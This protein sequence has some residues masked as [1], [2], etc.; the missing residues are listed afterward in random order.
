MTMETCLRR[1]PTLALFVTVL[2]IA[3]MPVG[4]AY[5]DCGSPANL[6]EAENCKPGNP[7]SE[8]DV[9][10]AGDENLQG[11]ATDISVDR[12]GTISFKVDTTA[13]AYRIDIYRLGYYQG[14]GA[15]LVA[16]IPNASTAK[17]SQPACVDQMSTTGLVDCGN[18]SVSASWAVP[19]DAVSG[20]YI[21]RLQGEAGVTGASHMVFVVRHD[22]S[23][24]DLLFQTSDTTW[25]AYNSYGGA[26]LY[27]GT[28][29]G[30]GLSGAGRAYKV[31]YNRP[32]NTRE[33]TPEDWI[34]D[35]E[36][37]MVRW[38]E[39]NGYDV[40]YTTGVDTAR[41]GSEILT[42]KAF[43]SVG[44]DEYWSGQQR[45]N[46]E[47]AR[48]HNP[49]VHLAFFSGNEIF[50][51]T[52]WE[53]SIAGTSTPYRTLV[54]YKETH[55]SPPEK[56][57]PSAEWTGTWRDPRFSP[58]SDGGR[59]E[60]ALSGTIFTVN[61]IQNDA[62][63][64]PEADGKMRFWRDTPNVANL[65]TGQVWSAPAGTL[66]YE[67]DEDL[68]NGARPPGLVR[69]STATVNVPGLLQDYGSTYAQGTATHHLA[70]HRR[71][72]GALVFGAGT[73]QWSWGLDSNHDRGSEPESQDMQQATVNLLADMGAQP[74][75]LQG[76]LSPASASADVV[77]PASDITSP[78]NDATA[79]LGVPVSILGTAS[80]G[81]PGLVGGVEVSVDGGA[82]WHSAAG[83][84]TWSYAWTPTT[85]GTY[86][87]LCRAVDDSGN[88]ESASAARRITVTSVP[89]SGST[90]V[91]TGTGVPYALSESAPTSIWAGT[92]T[93]ATVNDFDGQELELGVK[94]RSSSAGAITGIRFYKASRDGST[95]V[96]SLWSQSGT[97]LAAALSSTETASGWQEVALL[98]PVPIT[99]N[100]TYVASYHAKP[101]YYASSPGYF[102]QA[103]VNGPLTALAD[104]T[105][106][107]N[108]VYRYGASG[109]PTGSW[110]ASNYWVD[111]VFTPQATEPDTTPPVVMST[112]PAGG[113]TGVSVSTAVTVV[114]SEALAPAT[115]SGATVQL[116]DPA[117]QLVPAT[118]TWNAATTSAVLQPT[119]ALASAATYTA[120]IK[121]GAGGITD[122]TGNPLAADLT[123]TFTTQ[124]SDTVPPPSWYAGDMH[125]HRSCG[126]SP[127]SVT[128][129]YSKMATNNLATISLLAD[130][131]NGEVQDPTTDLPKV[132]G[133]DDSVSTPGR[134][135]HWDAEWHWDATYTQYPH[136]ALGGHIVALG[137]NQAQQVWEEYTYPIFQWA[138]AR[139]GIAGFAHMQYV[140]G[141]I[142]QSLDCC[143]P[144]E[145]PV[146]V[147][148]GSADFIE[149]DVTGSESAIEAYYR[150]LNTG[151]RPGFAAGTDYPCGVSTLGSLLTYVQV[152][153]GQ[154]T[155][156]NWIEGIAA[157]RTVVSRNGQNEFLSLTVNGA[158]T[159]GDQIN[160]TG[161]GTVS[162][163]IQWTAKQNLSGTIELVQN[164]VVVSSL[165]TSA[166]PGAPATLSTTASF[167]KSGWLAA[168]RM[169]GN[170]HQV[171]TAAVFVTVDSAPVRAS[172]DD[173]NFFV[174]WI[175]N[176]L[177][178]TD[179]GGEWS[180]FF[181]TKRA[182]ARA[183]Y[184][185]AKALFQQIAA[186]A[187]AEPPYV[188]AVAPAGGATNV[189]VSSA[190]TATFSE[191]L[192][193]A[194]VNGST[195]ELRDGSG[196]LVPATVTWNAATLSILLQPASA[197]AFSTT[198]TARIKGGSGGVTDVTGSPLA[199]D[200][201]WT[202]ATQASA[203]SGSASIWAGGGT[204]AILNGYDGQELELGVK[205]R[206]S[207]AGYIS[208][209]R[210]Y[211]G[212][213][214]TGTHTGSLWTS[215]G[216]LLATAPFVGETASG[217][218]E[219]TLPSPVAIAANTTYVASYHST[220][221]Y[222]VATLGYFTAAVT[223]GPLTAL[224]DGT[225]GPNGLYRYGATGFP[226]SSYN[227]S[228]YWVDV[229]FSV[230]PPGPDTT[231]P[232]VL[233]TTPT[234]GAAGTLVGSAV[235]AQFSELLAPATVTGATVFLRDS[236][237]FVV[238]ATVTWN[239]GTIAA[240]VQPTSALA[241][242]TTYTA[243]V[244][245]GSGG[246][247]DLAG[248]PLAADYSWTFTTQAAPLPPPEEGPGGPIL[249]IG[250]SGNPF[251]RYYAEILRAEGLNAFKAMDISAVDAT[252]LTQYDV[253]I[254][255]EMPLT[256]SQATMLADW[257]NG[258]GNLIAMRPAPQLAALLGLTSSG[259]T[260][261]QGYLAV[262]TNRAP[263]LGIVS[264]TV[265]FHGTAD[266]Y[267]I[268]AAT[269]PAIPV[270]TLYSNAT[271]ATNS[272][273][274]TLRPVGSAGGE[275]AAFAFDLAR[276][277]VYTRQGNPAWAGDERDGVSPVRSDDQFYGAKV[278]D[279]QPDW[280]NLGK[281]AIPQADEQ[282]RLLANLIL[283]MNADR[284]PLPR[285]WYF[286]RGEKAVVVMAVDNHGNQ[287]AEARFQAE[288]AAS[289][290]GCS[291]ADW[292][293]IRSSA[294][295]YAGALPSDAV[296]KQYEDAGFEIGVHVNTG[297]SDWTPTALA[298]YFTQQLADFASWYPSL[299]PQ[300]THR[301]HCIAWSDWAS[302]PKV[303][304]QNGIRLDTNYYYWPPTWVNNTP[305]FFTGSGMPMRFADLDGTMIDVYQAT[306]QMTDES[307]QTYPLTINTLLDNAIGSTGYY[308][309]F[310][311][312]I[313]ADGSTESQASA[314][315]ASAKARGV[316]V[317]SAKQMLAWLDG[318]NGS[319]FGAVSWSS[320]VL[321]FG[322]AVGAEANGLQ[323]M[324]PTSAGGSPLTAL[325]RGGVTVSFTKQ[326]MKGIEYAIFSAAPGT[327]QASYA[328]DATPPVISSVSAVVGTN[329]T[330][331][332]QWATDEPSTSLVRYG[333]S[334][335]SLTLSASSPLLLTTHSLVLTG[336]SGNTTYYYQVTSV[337]A[338][339]N[340]A[341]SAVS[342][343]LV[344]T[345]DTGPPTVTVV[346]PNGGERLYTG[347]PYTIRW[348]ATDDVGVTAIDVAV[349]AD[350]GTSFAAVTG[351]TGLAG[352][353]QSCTW[354]T[355]GP[356]TTQGRIR[357][358]A[359]DAAGQSGSATSAANFT[360]TS[361]TPSITL[362]APNT[363]VT[364]NVGTAQAITF[365]HNLGM[366][367]TVVIDLSR[368][369]GATW[370][371][372]N[373][374]FV[375]TSATTGSYGWTVTG[376]ATT[377]ARVR[378]TLSGNAAVTSASATSF[379]IADWITVTAPNTAV[380]WATGST[381]SITW[382][383]SLGTSQTVNIDL[384]RDG[385]TTWVSIAT[386]VTNA[387]ATTGTHS[388]LV[389]APATTQARVRVSASA[390]TAIADTSDTNFT[391][392]EMVSGTIT[393]TSPATGAQWGLATH[394][395]I[396]WDHTL[397]AGRTFNILLST[398][399]G[400]SF[401]TTIA[402]GVPAGATTG[403]YDWVVAGAT[404]TTARV[405]VVSTANAAIQGTTGNFRIRTASVT[406]TAPNTAVSWAIG[407]TRSITWT[408]YLGTQETVNIDESLDGGTT[409][410]SIATSVPHTTDTTG[411]YDWV[412]TG[413][414]S[415]TAR[416]RVTWTAN[417][418]VTDMSNQNLTVASPFVRVTSPNT[419][420][421][422]TIGSSRNL[423]FSHNLGTGQVVTIDISR[424]GGV[425]YSP[426]TS[427]TTTSATSG[428]YAWVVTG[429]ATTQGRVRVTWTADPAVTDTSNVNF[430]IR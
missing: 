15:R 414:A 407:T 183:R 254:L 299:T 400:S 321:T 342:S 290:A 154:M 385:G 79:A 240:I 316:P 147:A 99:A 403:S 408:Q 94:F 72:S 86:Q 8:W 118:V 125:V 282:Q 143:T 142:P 369:G 250:Y 231:A 58:P 30:S 228:N 274:V 47:A 43:L 133:A 153:G 215:A 270:A 48:D 189:P 127:E 219:V 357:V 175:D 45:T 53:A 311:A 28:G 223:T 139:N 264:Q 261:A 303:E 401:P 354:A 144:L 205:F 89:S 234:N 233:S 71:A 340:S 236:G 57:D 281:V 64:V 307:G 2:G 42:H 348:T 46:V 380:T 386:N 392:S 253:A 398:D 75:T 137:L 294:Y 90:S 350:G 191:P 285:F 129:L 323:A 425:T 170:G 35:A 164:G 244:K 112:S 203:P 291:V 421:A 24:S 339:G 63:Q 16:T 150:L 38:L 266:R 155:Y 187:A 279:V 232:T 50:W 91:R 117:A 415:T 105:D 275:A 326:T 251:S 60:N 21:A 402:S 372:I 259:T 116:R 317:V 224:A 172:V 241:Y 97:L 126:G 343:L 430:R 377:Q 7:S 370:A 210:F 156:R 93:P 217:W 3:S 122:V 174:Q 185:A 195:V 338:A 246:V 243:T 188:T 358:T 182:E 359:R 331:T 374:A 113:A 88:I 62:L 87:V 428:S 293:C 302:E 109:F 102:T 296:A 335:G 14:D 424:D 165:A 387:T 295:I 334:P 301:T 51:K 145:Y 41:R 225:D 181:P 177:T 130:M 361:G 77:A 141:G 308:G 267:T 96:V 186:E 314:I 20:I 27:W 140:G 69:L 237:G 411:S 211:K 173:A 394:R 356:A 399:G 26:S 49:P 248:N 417:S 176:L 349:S 214:D 235:T 163:N 119:S 395:T 59:P 104:G 422:W 352:T 258:G 82:T 218:Q 344:T 78:V 171:H 320:G 128:S 345:V 74:A 247:T 309:A 306:T 336:L 6:I 257:V 393:V 310:A 114:F 193:P 324:L 199:A 85:V 197:L 318:R 388:W 160:V 180:G 73:V 134:I 17:T 347:S 360:I 322:I 66:G 269:P 149:E 304:L 423:T 427:F 278:G 204:P 167:S 184:Q 107:G 201:N 378:L 255:G 332:V 351:C 106:G 70:F 341:T 115:V 152:A 108:G 319:S 391:I 252:V 242:S 379:T 169:D 315:V 222:Y 418:A 245:G 346:A 263:G 159:P 292:E 409:W 84:D 121:G 37:P 406:V 337:D 11:F 226:T 178:K 273:A 262:D 83:R 13:T 300:V 34:F 61:G 268:A 327:Y 396:T 353:A 25:Q 389:S 31:S 419:N 260:L 1:S 355:P 227:S 29:P 33:D 277:I 312:N 157:G 256:T 288:E 36:Y 371:T 95:H 120:T 405:R 146:E 230:N 249:V 202:F 213:L 365:N 404:T 271:T 413:P 55:T 397:G 80:D 229:V 196:L 383:H 158:A 123:W 333:T 52:R 136:Q 161:G 100:M 56:I 5:A 412:V 284:K 12:G 420:V 131:G 209:I 221:G 220:P 429:P 166:A 287:T 265:Q 384:S 206:S 375:T 280:V 151:F 19:A 298:G 110:N 92:G 313:H 32:F 111:V 98:A 76:D 132:T 272:P 168:R 67:W 190:V 40:S 363:A 44:H 101:G 416:I 276:S 283:T 10:G 148:L 382:N 390:N 138:H 207:Q 297:C 330:A 376:P 124:G 81:P 286:P 4:A 18:W 54:C 192:A 364:W 362:T 103:V 216:T 22:G 9:T 208:A 325:T 426:I 179:V 239:S 289:P 65:T 367:A 373:P 39:R 410:T 194:T 68:D 162:V 23:T 366:G 328:I 212:N 238:P 200:F 305:G 381:Q 368:D 135:V 198:Y 329:G